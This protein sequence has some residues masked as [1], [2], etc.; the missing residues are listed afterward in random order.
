[1]KLPRISPLT[2]IRQWD[3]FDH[4]DWLFELKHDGFRAVAYISDGECKL[5]SRRDNVYKS[6]KSLSETLGNPR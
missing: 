3:S 6:F 2:L 1:M 4:P 5:V